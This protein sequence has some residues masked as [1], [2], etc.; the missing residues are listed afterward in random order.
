MKTRFILV[1]VFLCALSANAQNYQTYTLYIHSF[2]KMIQWP[3]E[4]KKGDFEIFVLGESPVFEELQKMAEK[5]KLGDRVIKVSKIASLGDFRKGHMLFIP[6]A[7]SG[8]LT[9]ALTKIGEKSTLI[10]TEQTGLGAKGS[11]INFFMKD[12]KLA[13]ELNQAALAKHKLKAAIELSRL[14]TI[15]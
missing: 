10:I 8:K 15:I 6:A 12:G 3:E 9:D 2:A 11:G 13:F 7:Q 4:D 5:K 1:F 14:A